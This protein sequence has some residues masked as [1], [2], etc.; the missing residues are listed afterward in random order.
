MCPIREDGE[1]QRNGGSDALARSSRSADLRNASRAHGTRAVWK[2]ATCFS[3]AE[4]LC[5]SNSEMV[6]RNFFTLHIGPP[7]R[8][9]ERCC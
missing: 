8:R 3:M 1:V 4:D 5:R 7:Q 2:L 6:R 9:L